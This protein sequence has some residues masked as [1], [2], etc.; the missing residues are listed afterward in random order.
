[1]QHATALNP[2]EPTYPALE[3]TVYQELATNASGASGEKTAIGDLV[4]A[5]RLFAEAV[6]R[7][8]LDAPDLVNEADVDGYLSEVQPRQARSDLVAAAALARRAISEDPLNSDYQAF[9][10]QVLVA[11]HPKIAKKPVPK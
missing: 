4:Q 9:L 6:A 5:R 11:E 10:K 1:M 3:A 7:K 8:P 2:W